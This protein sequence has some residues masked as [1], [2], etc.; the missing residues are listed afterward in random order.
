MYLSQTKYIT[1][2]LH[3]LQMEDAATTVATHLQE[4][5]QA[6]D[7]NSPLLSNASVYRS[8]VERL[9]YLDFTRPDVTHDVHT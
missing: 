2:I 5:W 3:D 7:D 8:F 4:D 9:L 1:Y 6:Y